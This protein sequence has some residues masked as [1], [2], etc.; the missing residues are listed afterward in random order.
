METIEELASAKVNLTLRVLGRRR[1][2]Y[3]ELESLV[4]FATDA[5]DRLTFTPGPPL[6]VETTGPEASSIDGANLVATMIDAVLREHPALS[7]GAFHL[8]KNLPVAA[9]IGGGSADAAAAL[10]ALARANNITDPEAAFGVLAARF[11]ADIPVCIGGG[12]R[13]AAFMSGVGEIVWRPPSGSLLPPDGLSALLVNPR[14]AV[15]TGPVFETLDAP[16]LSAARA[17]GASPE[18]PPTFADAQAC[19]DYLDASGNSLEA[20]ASRIAPVIGDVLGHLRA[21]PGCRL[22]RMSGSGATCFGLFDDMEVAQRA[23]ELLA[24]KTAGW[25]IAASRLS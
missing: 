14:V 22:A 23:H 12:G 15:A 6:S 16:L 4:A 3:H 9:G 18:P 19:L 2:G 17:P 11:G 20:P 21:L 8:E 5:A 7:V 24:S 10:R 25:W 13:A 1:D